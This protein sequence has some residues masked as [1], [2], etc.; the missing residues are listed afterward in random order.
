MAPVRVRVI[1]VA[2]V[3]IPLHRPL[4]HRPTKPLQQ[5]LPPRSQLNFTLAKFTRRHIGRRQPFLHA[6]TVDQ[7]HRAC[8]KSEIN[9]SHEVSSTR[10]RTKGASGNQVFLALTSAVA[11]GD[12]VFLVVVFVANA[13]DSGRRGRSSSRI[14]HHAVRV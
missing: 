7:P 14:S 1:H 12:E 5:V 9:E 8:G 6:A 11:G 13:A 10:L 4:L 3:T 2:T